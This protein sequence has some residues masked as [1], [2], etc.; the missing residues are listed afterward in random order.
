MSETFIAAYVQ[1][2]LWSSTDESD[3]SGGKP[4]CE[5]YSMTSLSPETLAQMRHDCVHFLEENHENLNIVEPFCDMDRAGHN[6]WLNRN[7]HG[8]GFWDEYNGNSKSIRKAFTRLS[9]AS[10]VYGSFDLYIGDDGMIYG[11]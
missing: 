9:D 1:C 6:F 7:R 3:E 2:A 4:L 10:K 11:N 5:N 8:S